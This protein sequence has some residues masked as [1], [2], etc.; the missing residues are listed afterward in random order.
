MALHCNNGCLCDDSF[1]RNFAS[2]KEMHNDEIE[3]RH[4]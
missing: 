3:I 1:L 2:Q 4:G